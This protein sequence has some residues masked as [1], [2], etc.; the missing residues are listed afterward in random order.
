VGAGALTLGALTLVSDGTVEEAQAIHG[1]AALTLAALTFNAAGVVAFVAIISRVRGPGGRGGTV[2][3]SGGAG[4]VAGAAATGT[5]TG[6]GGTGSVRGPRATNK[7]G[8]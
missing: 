5:V 6:T 1:E 2:V 7:T 4:T 3:S 8:A